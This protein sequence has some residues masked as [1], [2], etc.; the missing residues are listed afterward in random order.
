VKTC[1][2]TVTKT[3]AEDATDTFIFTITGNGVTLRV[4]V[5]GN[6]SQTIVGLPVGTY[7]VTEASGWSWRYDA[8]SVN[9]TLSHTNAT[10]SVTV[11][12]ELENDRWLSGDSQAVNSFPPAG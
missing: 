8:T 6:G 11:Q 1:S 7:T 10:A 4:S 2:L 3:G 5:Q 9:V 12:N